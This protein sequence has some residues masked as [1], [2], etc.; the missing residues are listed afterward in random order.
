VVISND[1]SLALEDVNVAVYIR[2]IQ[3]PRYGINKMAGTKYQPPTREID[4]GDKKTIELFPVSVGVGSP[5]VHVDI[6]LI[7]CY[8]PEF[9]PEWLW[10]GMPKVFRFDSALQSDGTTRL[11]QQPDD[12][13]ILSEYERFIGTKACSASN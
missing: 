10:F 11:R 6:G 2:N 12:G 1:G 8:R 7:V 3:G 5:I 13:K 9:V 4:I